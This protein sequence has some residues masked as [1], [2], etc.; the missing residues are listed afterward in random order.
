MNKIEK[1]HLE[2][3]KKESKKLNLEN[4]KIIFEEYRYSR[5]LKCY[6]GKQIIKSEYNIYSILLTEKHKNEKIK[7]TNTIITDNLLNALKK[8]E[9]WKDEINEKG[10]YTS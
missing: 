10:I 9:L 8:L 7:W 6:L 1:Y 4:D 2:K 3:F 5:A